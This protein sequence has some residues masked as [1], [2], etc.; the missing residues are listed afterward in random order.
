[1]IANALQTFINWCLYRIEVLCIPEWYDGIT[2]WRLWGELNKFQRIN[3][4]AGAGQ[5]T[6]R[7]LSIVCITRKLFFW[8]SHGKRIRGNKHM[9]QRI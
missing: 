9:A 5:D 8:T 1:M 3:Q 4:V 2:S 7:S 6:L